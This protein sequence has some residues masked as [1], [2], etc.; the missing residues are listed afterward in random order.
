MVQAHPYPTPNIPICDFSCNQTF[1]PR[2]EAIVERA[3]VA[4]K[5]IVII[6]G[7]ALV[8]LGAEV[9]HQDADGDG[10]VDWCESWSGCW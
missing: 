2:D 6:S 8:R 7:I 5:A 3:A 1:T 9:V 10:R 4:S